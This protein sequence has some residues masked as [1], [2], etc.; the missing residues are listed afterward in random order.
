MIND[1]L[2]INICDLIHCRDIFSL[3][4]GDIE[5]EQDIKSLKYYDI[6]GG[7]GL[8]Y[9]PYDGSNYILSQ[10]C[11]NQY[12]HYFDVFI[13]VCDMT[14]DNYV[15]E[16]INICNRS[17]T[18]LKLII[19]CPILTAEYTD[20]F[21]QET[22]SKVI[23]YKNI[24]IRPII[25]YLKNDESSTIGHYIVANSK[26]YDDFDDGK[27]SDFIDILSE[28]FLPQNQIIFKVP[29]EEIEV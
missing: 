2:H 24:V 7:I 26:Y 15:Q 25:N 9:D 3:Y 5:Y 21:H 18:S 20:K 22:L 19:F 6:F 27:V 8:I 10:D 29:S 4:I 1:R 13:I 28:E 23:S 11:L 12:C 17:Y 16:A 14:H